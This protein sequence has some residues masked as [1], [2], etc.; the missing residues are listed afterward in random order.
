MDAIKFRWVDGPTC[1]DADWERIEAILVTRGWMSLNRATSRILVAEDA[2]RKLLGFQVLQ[3]VPHVEPLYVAPSA[4][5]TGLAEELVERMI[6]FLGEVQIRGYLATAESPFAAQI[7]ERH[8]MT[9][10]EYP[11]YAKVGMTERKGS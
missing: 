1:D 9:K 8:G 3:L 7:C 2:D 6:K 11:V 5:A 4:R 10:L